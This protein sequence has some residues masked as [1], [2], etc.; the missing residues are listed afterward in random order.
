VATNLFAQNSGYP[1]NLRFFFF[2]NRKSPVNTDKVASCL[3]AFLLQLSAKSTEVELLL[4]RFG[5]GWTACDSQ[6]LPMEE[7]EKFYSSL[8]AFNSKV[9]L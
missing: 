3:L 7:N 6:D 9:Q 2:Q 5:A 4:G 8:F 1:E